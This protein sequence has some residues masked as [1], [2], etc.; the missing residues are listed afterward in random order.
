MLPWRTIPNSKFK[1]PNSK[2]AEA[3]GYLIMALL[4]PIQV[5]IQVVV[6][7]APINFIH[8]NVMYE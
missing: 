5:P 8:N 7:Y 1:N 6:V 4:I 3:H 2:F